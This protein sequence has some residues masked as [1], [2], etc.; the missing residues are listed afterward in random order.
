MVCL[1]VS[2]LDGKNEMIA[3]AE[4]RAAIFFLLK[5][6]KI[7]ISSFALVGSSD[8][9]EGIFYFVSLD[10]VRARWLGAA[11]FVESE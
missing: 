7:E 6:Y 1:D 3:V 8:S 11:A 2:S 10:R 4:M 9:G 5:K